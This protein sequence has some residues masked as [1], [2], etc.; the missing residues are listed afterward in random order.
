MNTLRNLSDNISK[1]SE[2]IEQNKV[3]MDRQFANL[4][5]EAK[6]KGN[7]PKSQGGVK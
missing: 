1:T 4:V 7:E 5:T 2:T 3:I 6:V